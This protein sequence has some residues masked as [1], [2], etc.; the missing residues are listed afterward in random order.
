MNKNTINFQPLSDIPKP[1]SI[2]MDQRGQDQ[3]HTII[4]TIPPREQVYWTP[5]RATVHR[6]SKADTPAGFD[7]RETGF[8]AVGRCGQLKRWVVLCFA[9]LHRGQLGE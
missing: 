4:I 7:Q 1:S 9:T 2:L 3:A 6:S 8:N 5:E